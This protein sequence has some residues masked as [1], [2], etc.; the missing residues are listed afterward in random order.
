MIWFFL[1]DRCVE[2]ESSR[3]V[4]KIIIRGQLDVDTDINPDIHIWFVGAN[5]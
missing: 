1:K 4:L 5:P 2:E 3:V